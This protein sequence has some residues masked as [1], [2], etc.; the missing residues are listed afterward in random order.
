ME[1]GESNLAD[2]GY[3]V[4]L[5]KFSITFPRAEPKIAFDALEP[6]L[7]VCLDRKVIEWNNSAL[8]GRL[9]GCDE[10]A[11]RSIVGGPIDGPPLA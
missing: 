7:Q 5:C 3:Q 11:V 2:L 1:P 6:L 8:V 10:F 4:N 9:L